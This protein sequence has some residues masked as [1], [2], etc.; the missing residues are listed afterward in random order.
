MAADL[1]IA[2]D[3][4]DIARMR[5]YDTID[6]EPVGIPKQLNDF[7]ENNMFAYAQLDFKPLAWLKLTVIHPTF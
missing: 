6:R 5:Q 1:L 7:S 4:A 3:R 2:G